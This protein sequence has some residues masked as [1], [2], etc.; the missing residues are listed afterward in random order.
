MMANLN[1]IIKDIKITFKKNN[2]ILIIALFIFIISFLIS[3]AFITSLNISWKGSLNNPLFFSIIYKKNILYN[4][5]KNNLLVVS[6][7][8]FGCLTMSL[9]TIL[10]LIV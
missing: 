2:H 3:V 7:T 6:I 9:S 4:V 1:D 8:I 10:E 5:L